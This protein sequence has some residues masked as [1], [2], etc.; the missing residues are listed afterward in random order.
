M[1]ESTLT[2]SHWILDDASSPQHTFLL[3]DM[4]REGCIVSAQGTSPVWQIGRPLLP[5]LSVCGDTVAWLEA[6]LRE[7][8]TSPLLLGLGDEIWRADP[9]LYLST[10]LLLLS[11]CPAAAD[12]V[13]TL[14]ENQML[15]AAVQAHGL[16]PHAAL[17]A[18]P[19][20]KM[21]CSAC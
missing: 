19:H 18:M 11:R 7:N 15:G 20:R 1:P 17:P 8:T 13:V 12:T 16:P 2:A 10:G 14:W 9:Q 5:L 6:R 21:R 3:A 4:N